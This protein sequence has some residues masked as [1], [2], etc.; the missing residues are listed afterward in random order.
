MNFT[1]SGAIMN[2]RVI[3]AKK[4]VFFWK[5]YG[6]AYIMLLPNFIMFCTFVLYPV[7][8]ALRFMFFDSDGVGLAKFVGLDNFIRVFTHDLPW[9]QS[10]I[11]TFIFAFGKLAI[12]LPVAILLAA[13]LNTKIFG[14]SLFRG[15]F[16][17]PVVTGA[18][19]MSLAFSFMFSPYNGIINSIL[20]KAGLIDKNLNWLADPKLAMMCCILIAVWHYFGSNVLLVLSGLQGIPTEMYESAYI[21]GATKI[22]V[23]KY[24]TL[25]MLAPVLQVIFMLALIGSMKEF[26][27]LF[28]LTG[29][30]PNH[31]TD[32]M[33][34]HIYNQFFSKEQY[35]SYGYGATL[36]FISS[37]VIGLITAIY[38]MISKKMKEIYE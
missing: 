36:G 38:L 32:V 14:R 15:I 22:Q 4:K 18:A 24:I 10:I 1:K 13:I 19:V 20:V 21:D 5:E 37:I 25:P 34:L 33:N 9:W 8:W 17:L 35:P 3:M 26:D 6:S 23:F 11:N 31:A 12:E 29:G 27:I 7:S 28:V 30:G 2:S 16:Y